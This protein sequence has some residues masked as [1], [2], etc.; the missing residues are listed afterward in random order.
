MYYINLF[1][2]KKYRLQSITK[3]CYEMLLTIFPHKNHQ[4]FDEAKY[5]YFLKVFNLKMLLFFGFF[6][7]K[8]SYLLT[9]K[10]TL[11]ANNSLIQYYS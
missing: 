7:M 5:Y 8:R 10:I 4:N 2:R 11:D 6:P 9:P 3:K 1:S